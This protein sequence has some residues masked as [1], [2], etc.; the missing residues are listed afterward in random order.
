MSTFVK[1][2]GSLPKEAVVFNQE[3][4]LYAGCLRFK[5]VPEQYAD[6]SSVYEAEDAF[7][8]GAYEKLLGENDEITKKVMEEHGQTGHAGLLTP[9]IAKRRI[10]ENKD[11][12]FNM[13]K[14][15][16]A[17]WMEDYEK[18]P[19]VLIHRDEELEAKVGDLR[20]GKRDVEEE[21]VW[22]PEDEF[23]VDVVSMDKPASQPVL[24]DNQVS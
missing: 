3:Y 10:D 13:F 12:N 11:F 16:P 19:V 23:L 5:V 14:E 20:G 21:Y 24:A 1:V 15:I 7:F 8:N 4:Y 6:W 18:M 2:S 9:E 17:S 22:L